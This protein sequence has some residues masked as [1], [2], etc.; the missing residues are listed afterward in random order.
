MR[1]FVWY[2]LFAIYFLTGNLKKTADKDGPQKD[3][4]MPQNHRLA[5]FKGTT[6]KI[7][8]YLTR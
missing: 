8:W 1:L 7:L 4:W 6:R 5:F 2:K 3:T